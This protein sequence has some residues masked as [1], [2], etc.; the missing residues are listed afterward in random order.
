MKAHQITKLPEILFQ[1]GKAIGSEEGLSKTLRTIS[2]LVTELCDAEACSIMLVDHSRRILLGKAEYGLGRDDISAVSFRLGEGVAGWVADRCEPAII[3]DV[4]CDDR[5]KVLPDSENRIRSLACVPMVYREEVVGVMTI[6]SPQE[7]AF[8]ESAVEVLRFVARTIALDLEN[9]R[10]RRL[11]VTDRLT[12]AFNRE[13]L[14]QKLPAAI[15]DASRRGEFLSIAMID[16]DHFKTVNDRFG[17]SVGDEVLA[18]VAGV[19]RG[20]TREGDLLVRYGGEE[21]LLLFPGTDLATAR[22]ISDRMRLRM[23]DAPVVACEHSVEIRLSAGV[24]QCEKD[25]QAAELMRRADAAL[26]RAKASGR[27][28]VEVAD[29]VQ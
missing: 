20:A 8:E 26:Y 27:N 23:M 5:Y 7:H 6:T 22:D 19:L 14:D 28:R 10:L 16:V 29:G 24:A 21:F 3:G 18:A 15:Q 12:G 13:F 4:T 9:I 11:A 17:H 1:I 2:E 25:E